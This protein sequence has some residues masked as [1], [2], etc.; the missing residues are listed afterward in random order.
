MVY[1]FWKELNFLK[2]YSIRQLRKNPH[3]SDFLKKDQ[4]NCATESH[5]AE[6]HL[7]L[8]ILA[9][10]CLK[11]S[12]LLCIW[13]ALLWFRLECCFICILFK[14]P[15]NQKQWEKYWTQQLKKNKNQA[16]FST[17]LNLLI[18]VGDLRKAMKN[19]MC[20]WW[21]FPFSDTSCLVAS[22]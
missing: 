13:K 14:N 12:Q 8:S 10:F 15:L 2:M 9:D 18:P 11:P 22:V 1:M 4:N 20:W 7:A 19:L 17:L 16:S 6:T 3:I 5:L 21:S